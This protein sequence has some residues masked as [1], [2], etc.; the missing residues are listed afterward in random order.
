MLTAL[1]I[2]NFAILEQIELTVESGFTVLTGETGAGKSLLIDAIE[3]LMGGR[4]S[5]DQIR[6]GQEEAVVEAAFDIPPDHPILATL[7]AQG[8]VG[9]TDTQLVVR[10]I[11]ARSGRSR[12]YLNGT[13]SPVHALEA[14][15]GVLVD[16]HGQHDQQSLLAPSTQLEALD[17]FGRLHELRDRYRECYRDWV[18]LRREREGAAVKAQ[19]AAQREDY[20]TFQCR[21]LDDAALRP[22][23]EEALESERRRLAASHRLGELVGEAQARLVEQNDGILPNVALVERLLGEM[24]RLDQT[25]QEP[26][27]LIAE[28]KVLVKE[29]A[30]RLRDYVGQLETDPGRLAVV[31]DRIALIQRLKKKY[32]GTVQAALE[33]HRRLKEELQSIQR[34]D[35]EIGRYD[36]LIQERWAQVERLAQEL[37]QKRREAAGRMTEIVCRELDALK[38][39]QAQFQIEI[40]KGEGDNAYGSEG[41]DRVEFLFSANRGEPLKPLSRVASGGEIS[42]VMLAL[43]SALAGADRV[44]IIIFDEIDTGVGGAAA[45]AI[46]KRLKTL[47]R[48]H[49]VLCVTHLPQVASQADHHWYLEKALVKDRST[50][51]VRLLKG[52]SREKEI[53]RMLAGETVTKKIRET[54]AELIGGATE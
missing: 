36:I 21:E 51:V 37:S 27:R 39:D 34:S 30:D 41:A 44:P 40:A 8:I 26:V 18:R 17:A 16:I 23:E 35:E 9:E 53:A 28:A 38:M 2:S 52:A 47:G 46:G 20:L 4:A 3:L 31:E 5:S 13:M 50:T 1:R 54:A 14:L 32:G 6:F 11:I 29:V 42:R 15:G 22:G 33:S 12:A 43:K 10:R 25:I 24:A 19:E 45:A 49:Q 7:R 48:S